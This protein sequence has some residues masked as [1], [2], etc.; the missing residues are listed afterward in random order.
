MSP[1]SPDG[2]I[3]AL[4][5]TMKHTAETAQRDRSEMRDEIKSLATTVATGFTGVHAAI[6]G[7]QDRVDEIERARLESKSETRGMMRV[8][9][10]IASFSGATLALIGKMLLQSFGMFK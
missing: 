3:G 9:A 7:V 4:E 10:L 6:S 1:P 5:A 8:L 2:R